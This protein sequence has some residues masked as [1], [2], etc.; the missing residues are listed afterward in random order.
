[1]TRRAIKKHVPFACF[2]NALLHLLVDTY[3]IQQIYIL[4]ILYMNIFA[5]LCPPNW[6]SACKSMPNLSSNHCMLSPLLSAKILTSSGSDNPC[7]LFKV[8][9]TN[10]STESCTCDFS[11]GLVTAPLIPKLCC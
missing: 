10:S 6:L 9:C 1:M 5:Y 7:P 2:E 3:K 8:S 11:W 4:Y